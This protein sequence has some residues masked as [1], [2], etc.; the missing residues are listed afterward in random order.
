MESQQNSFSAFEA[1]NVLYHSTFR[2]RENTVQTL[3]GHKK[4][5]QPA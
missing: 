4:S 5:V 2:R 3:K 1:L